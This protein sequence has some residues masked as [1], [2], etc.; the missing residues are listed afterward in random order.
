MSFKTQPENI[1]HNFVKIIYYE[2][3]NNCIDD[4]YQYPVYFCSS[5]R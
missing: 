5:K 4:D 1:S 3:F 2:S